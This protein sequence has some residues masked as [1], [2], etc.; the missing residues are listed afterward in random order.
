V[1]QKHAYTS[2]LDVFQAGSKGRIARQDGGDIPHL[3]D[4]LPGD[5]CHLA[6]DRGVNGAARFAVS[7]WEGRRNG[8]A[9]V[10]VVERLPGEFTKIIKYFFCFDR[11]TTLAT[12]LSYWVNR[13][14]K[15]PL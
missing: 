15:S 10:D 6:Q 9:D 11:N 13:V 7:Q 4:I 3:G 8:D 14:A 12:W 2:R 5:E 1:F